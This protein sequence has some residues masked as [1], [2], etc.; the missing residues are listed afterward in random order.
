MRQ[1][2][3]Y[4]IHLRV[5]SRR[6]SRK[7]Q[8][9]Q[10][11]MAMAPHSHTHKARELQT[12]PKNPWSQPHAR[13]RR[14]LHTRTRKILPNKKHKTAQNKPIARHPKQPIRH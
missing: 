12:T 14:R 7:K 10:K 3:F 6:K 1:L 9:P 11:H 5:N 4:E 8:T 13:S 2:L